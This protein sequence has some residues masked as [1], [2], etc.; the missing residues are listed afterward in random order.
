MRGVRAAQ[1]VQHHEVVDDPLV[2][3]GGHRHARLAQPGGV[4]LALVAQDV[5]LGGDDQ[6]R[7]QAGQLLG[8]SAQR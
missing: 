5:R 7:R 8:G 3:D 1:R 2:A 4:R 6:G